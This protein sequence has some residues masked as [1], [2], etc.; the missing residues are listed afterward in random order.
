MCQNPVTDYGVVRIKVFSSIISNVCL[1]GLIL[2]YHYVLLIYCDTF[3]LFVYRFLNIV[4]KPL[5]RYIVALSQNIKAYK[6]R[7]RCNLL[8]RVSATFLK[9]SRQTNGKYVSKLIQHLNMLVSNQDV[10]LLCDKS[11][12][13]LF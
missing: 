4:S 6:I 7:E 11:D 3:S 13:L 12:Q 5:N 10:M 9:L 2:L 8:P 1:T